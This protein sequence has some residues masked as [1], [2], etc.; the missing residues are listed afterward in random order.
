M[1]QFIQRAVAIKGLTEREHFWIERIR[2]W[3]VGRICRSLTH[4]V[5]LC[6]RRAVEVVRIPQQDTPLFSTPS[7]T[8]LLTIAQKPGNDML[9]EHLQ[10]R[11]EAIGEYS[12][13]SGE[14]MWP[15]PEILNDVFPNTELVCSD[16]VDYFDTDESVL[17]VLNVL[18]QFLADAENLK[19][20]I[21][22]CAVELF[23]DMYAPQMNSMQ[24]S[25]YLDFKGQIDDSLILKSLTPKCI[26]LLRSNVNIQIQP[27]Y[28]CDWDDDHGFQCIIIDGKIFKPWKE[29]KYS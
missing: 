26:E 3:N 22:Q 23:R 8:R 24:L 1:D 5:S 6:P 4:G 7:R 13:E 11:L 16:V 10:A 25:R 12:G 19:V 27:S 17:Q 21:A 29:E 9:S 18:S 28:S 2:G 15:S 14:L 20:Q